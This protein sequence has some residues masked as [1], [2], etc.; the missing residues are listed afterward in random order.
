[1]AKEHETIDLIRGFW[2]KLYPGFLRGKRIN[3]VSLQAEAW[4]WRVTAA[5]DDF[6][7]IDAEPL[8]LMDATKGRRQ[9]VS[10]G[11]VKQWMKEMADVDLVRLYHVEDECFWHVVGF[12][13][14]QTPRNGRRARRYPS[15]PWDE[16]ESLGVIRGKPGETGGNSGKEVLLDLDLDQTQIK[17]KNQIPP[18]EVCS[19]PASRAAEP[20]APPLMMFDCLKGKTCPTGKWALSPEFF[21][22]LKTSFPGIDAERS[23][24]GAKAWCL[25]NESKR[26]T[27]GGMKKFLVGW[28]SRDQDRAGAGGSPTKTARERMIDQKKVS[29]DNL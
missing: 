27:H 3:A 9:G 14:M 15:S 16:N 21:E 19:E 12:T 17:T 26:K 13:E 10:V 28:L 8:L 22:E 20:A 2:R 11:N 24:L 4:F 6:G 18:T 23:C 7:N 29:V 1:M 25:A 5:V